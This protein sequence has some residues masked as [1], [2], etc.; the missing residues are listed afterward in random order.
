[1]KLAVVEHETL[2]WVTRQQPVTFQ[3]AMVDE[4]ATALLRRLTTAVRATC[5]ERVGGPEPTFLDGLV[6]FG[7]GN[8][9]GEVDDEASRE[10]HCE[11]G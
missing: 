6:L 4:L 11:V 8:D 9:V 1:V 3:A 10:M 7:R 5:M 2:V